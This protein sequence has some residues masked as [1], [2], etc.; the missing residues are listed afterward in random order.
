MWTRT[1][2]RRFGLIESP[3]R[4]LWILTEAG[5]Q[6]TS[7]DP[8]EVVR[9]VRSL[10]EAERVE[11]GG[12]AP[13]FDEEPASE[14]PAEPAAGF[15]VIVGRDPAVVGAG[16]LAPRSAPVNGAVITRLLPGA[17]LT[18]LDPPD[19]ASARIGILGHWLNVR[20]R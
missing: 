10:M 12:Q 18:V 11:R 2:L 9:T 5:Q 14:P 3:R 6:V 4:G 15:T 13:I 17:L 1:Y 7:V 16:G 8:R 20:D 19:V